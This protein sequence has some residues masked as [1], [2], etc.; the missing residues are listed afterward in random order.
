MAHISH[1]N[2]V[3]VFQVV[4]LADRIAIAL[5][6]IY[7]VTARRPLRPDCESSGP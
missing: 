1:P 3:P 6:F 4:K 7:G 2:V 5:E